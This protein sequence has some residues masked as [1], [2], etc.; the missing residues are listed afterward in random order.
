MDCRNECNSIREIK[1][2]MDSL[3]VKVNEVHNCLVGETSDP[4]KL[5]LKSAV[6]SN[7]RQLRTHAKIFWFSFSGIIIVLA[8]IAVRL[9]MGI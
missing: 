1:L 3:C 6:H 9:F 8:T 5:G 7:K 2:K 4:T